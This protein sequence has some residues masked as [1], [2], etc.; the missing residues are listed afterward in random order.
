MCILCGCDYLPKIIGM[1][2]ISAY[3]LISKFKTIEVFL[4][5]NTKFIIPE[6]FDYVKARYLFKNPLDLS[7]I[8]DMKNSIK[9]STPKV[10][11]LKDFLKNTKLKE[12]FINEI[13]NNL[14][15]YFLNIQNINNLE[16]TL[17]G[18]CTTESKKIT[19]FFAKV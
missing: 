15:S 14:M 2:P 11:E 9:I 4:E 16:K 18:S 17:S 13:G 10:E 1:G 5:N 3:K 8:G 12:K 6:D 19:D 7:L